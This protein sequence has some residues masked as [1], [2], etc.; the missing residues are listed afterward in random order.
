MTSGS[1]RISPLNPIRDLGGIDYER[2]GALHNE[3]RERG[4][5]GAGHSLDSLDRTTYW[6]RCH[7]DPS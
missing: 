2:C 3:I 1:W 5:V 7:D 6:E 4:W